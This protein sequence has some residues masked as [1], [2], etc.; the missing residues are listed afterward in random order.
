M[1]GLVVLLDERYY[2][3]GDRILTFSPSVKFFSRLSS[4]FSSIRVFAP[5]HSRVEGDPQIDPS[6]FG[7]QVVPL[8]PW[9]GFC[10]FVPVFLRHPMKWLAQFR[11]AVAAG[12]VVWVRLPSLAGLTLG[13]VAVL[14][15]NPLVV[16]L[17]AD[18]RWLGS[19]HITP[20]RRYLA[21][22]AGLILH[23]VTVAL[24]SRAKVVL[25]TGDPCTESLNRW[26]IECIPF[27]DST[28][29]QTLLDQSYEKPVRE[30]TS[31]LS[32]GRFSNEKGVQL[33]VQSVARLADEIPLS[34]TLVGYGN[35][36]TGLPK[37]DWLEVLNGVSHGAELWRYYAEADVF[38]FSSTSR[39]EGIPRVLLEAMAFQ[40]AIV[41][42][43]IGGVSSLLEHGVD[44]LL[45]PPGDVNSL[46]DALRSLLVSRSLRD[47]LGLAASKKVRQYT[48]E[49][50]SSLVANKLSL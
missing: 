40:C 33:I 44:A 8:D 2:R 9:A 1:A 30:K 22:A 35:A 19:W 37:Y 16:H 14:Q 24:C 11:R 43:N 18:T 13:I 3:V 21:R 38:V 27:V 15:G 45:V 46:T 10:G 41:A 5:V 39:T 17:A 25:T 48:A 47:E 7:I 23:L 4:V 34:L 28:V 36:V 31:I 49:F 12:D 29:D 20:L 26:G 32:V 42:T 6:L 50:E